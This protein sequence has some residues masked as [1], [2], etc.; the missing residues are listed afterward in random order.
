MQRNRAVPSRPA[1]GV[2]T[3]WWPEHCVIVP[4]LPRS[5]GGKIAKSELR[6]QAAALAAI[7]SAD[8]DMPTPVAVAE[9]KTA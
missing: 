8:A 7:T 6:Q 5:S 1:R 9:A 2:S 3:E 4:E